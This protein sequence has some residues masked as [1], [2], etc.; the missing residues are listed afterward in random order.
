MKLNFKFS[1]FDQLSASNRYSSVRRLKISW[2]SLAVS[3]RADDEF[4]EG[5]LGNQ[6]LKKLYYL[7]DSESGFESR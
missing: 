2:N 5:I 1:T 4:G 6:K 3:R 7:N